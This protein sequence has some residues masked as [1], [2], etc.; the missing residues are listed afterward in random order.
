MTIDPIEWMKTEEKI[1]K[2]EET[3]ENE[4]NLMIQETKPLKREETEKEVNQALNL[5]INLREKENAPTLVKNTK[6]TRE[7]KFSSIREKELQAAARATNVVKTESTTEADL[8]SWEKAKE[9]TFQ[10]VQVHADHHLKLWKLLRNIELK[11]VLLKILCN[12]VS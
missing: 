12:R 2:A 3:K 1:G 4:I 9:E 7:E 11:R 5:I 8:L 10:A 6:T